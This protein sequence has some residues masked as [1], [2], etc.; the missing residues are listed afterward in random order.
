MATYL[1][2]LIQR[3]TTKADLKGFDDLDKKQKRARK[4]NNL[5][6]RSFRNAF[7]MFLGIQGV[8]SIV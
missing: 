4:E 6:A 2:E 3:I 8:R 1:D 7:G 5:L